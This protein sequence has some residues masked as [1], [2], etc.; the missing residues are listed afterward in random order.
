MRPEPLPALKGK[1]GKEFIKQ[2]ER[3]LS[4]SE[5]ETFRKAERVFK[6]IKSAK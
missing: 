6:G 5:L 4:P 2:V 1:S 3:P